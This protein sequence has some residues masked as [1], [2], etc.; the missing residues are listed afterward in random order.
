MKILA[1]SVLNSVTQDKIK[2]LVFRK[3][4]QDKQQVREKLA[5]ALTAPAKNKSPPFGGFL[6]LRERKLDLNSRRSEFD[7]KA[8]VDENTPVGFADC[9]SERSNLT[10]PANNSNTAQSGVFLFY[11]IFTSS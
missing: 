9:R 3:N 5:G 4:T 7:Y 2:T 1:Y 8:K 10:A 11:N 6:F